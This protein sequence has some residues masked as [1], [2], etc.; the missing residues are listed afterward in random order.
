MATCVLVW[1][2]EVADGIYHHYLAPGDDDGEPCGK[3]QVVNGDA[4][5]ASRLA[6][7]LSLRLGGVE[8]IEDLNYSKGV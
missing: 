2:E 6:V 7:V 1:S 5:D 3:I 8:I 4:W